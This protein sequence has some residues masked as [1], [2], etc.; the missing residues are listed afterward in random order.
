MKNMI[1]VLLLTGL[2]LTIGLV[3]AAGGKALGKVIEYHQNSEVAGR[4]ACIQMDP[5]IP[6]AGGWACLYTNN[7]LYREITAL[8]LSGNATGNNCQVAWSATGEWG[9]AVIAWVS[10]YSPGK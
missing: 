1:S 8:L 3:H 6:A 7:A 2:L 10:C 9:E 4:G 5:A